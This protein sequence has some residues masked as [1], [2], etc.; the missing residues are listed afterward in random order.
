MVVLSQ[1]HPT[2]QISSQGLCAVMCV[3]DYIDTHARVGVGWPS[4]DGTVSAIAASLGSTELSRHARAGMEDAL[5]QFDA[6]GLASCE[7]VFP[8]SD[9][10]AMRSRVCLAAALE[11][12]AAE[13]LKLAGELASASSSAGFSFGSTSTPLAVIRPLHVRVCGVFAFQVALFAIFS[14]CLANGVDGGVA[15]RVLDVALVLCSVFFLIL[16]WLEHRGQG[17]GSILQSA[18]SILS[19][20]FDM[21]DSLS[22]VL[23]A[24]CAVARLLRQTLCRYCSAVR[25]VLLHPDLRIPYS[26]RHRPRAPVLEIP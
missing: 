10:V 19:N 5:E 20:G 15:S 6:G 21:G 26:R 16:E 18:G 13:V 24:G 9:R 2:I 7:L 22:A 3:L 25:L 1:V 17:A 14:V 12:V 4:A 8:V 23:A 11:H